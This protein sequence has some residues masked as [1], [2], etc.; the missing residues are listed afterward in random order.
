MEAREG[1]LALELVKLAVA[2]SSHEFKLAVA[3]SSH[4][5]VVGVG[6]K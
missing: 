4:E 2:N 6:K 3:N 5:F 1:V